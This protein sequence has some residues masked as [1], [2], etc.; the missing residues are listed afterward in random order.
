MIPTTTQ[1]IGGDE[2]DASVNINDIDLSLSIPR[3]VDETG[4]T[5]ASP[6]RFRACT[7]EKDENKLSE[8]SRHRTEN[9][10]VI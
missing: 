1:G 10:E 8:S 7:S 4:T 5:V 3:D 9:S 2:A 6:E